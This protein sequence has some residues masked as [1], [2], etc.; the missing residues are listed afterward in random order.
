MNYELLL[1]LPVTNEEQQTKQFEK[2][3]SFITDNNGVI[4]RN[5][6]WGNKALAYEYPDHTR[7]IYY[8][9]GFSCSPIITKNLHD[10]IMQDVK[11]NIV[12]RHMI[13]KKHTI[14]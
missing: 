13:I 2:Y 10:Q 11:N 4:N 9:L 12:I 7:G 5:E 6:C 3:V 8:L 1:I 14:Y